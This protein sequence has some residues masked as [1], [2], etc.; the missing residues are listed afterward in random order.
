M[1]KNERCRKRGEQVIVKDPFNHR[2][3]NVQA[4]K[5]QDEWGT[6]AQTN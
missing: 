6:E 2:E 1:G 5:W 4:G 3:V